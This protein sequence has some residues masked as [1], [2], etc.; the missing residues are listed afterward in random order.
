MATRV[1]RLVLKRAD[2]SEEVLEV[3][4]VTAIR[5]QPGEMKMV[6]HLDKLA[7]GTYRLTY[8]TGILDESIDFASLARI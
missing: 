8:S 2:G 3:S 7:N 6:F 1:E 5:D 4:K